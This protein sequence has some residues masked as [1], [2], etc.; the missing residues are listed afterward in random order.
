MNDFLLTAF[1]SWMGNMGMKPSKTYLEYAADCRRIA[2][3]M[4]ARRDREVLL[5]MAEAWDLRA[6][7]AEKKS[8]DGKGD[9]EDSTTTAF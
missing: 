1:V 5:K 8:T 2:G 7:H 4:K 9:G 6:Q 3:S